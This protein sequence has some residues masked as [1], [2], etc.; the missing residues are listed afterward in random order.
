MS[1]S[2]TATPGVQVADS[3]GTPPDIC[4]FAICCCILCI[5]LAGYNSRG[6]HTSLQM[7]LASTGELKLFAS[8][9]ACIH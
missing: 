1:G 7:Q 6:L 5:L 4:C 9:V 3:A 8:D 2:G